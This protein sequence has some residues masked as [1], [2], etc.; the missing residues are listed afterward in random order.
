MPASI[1]ATA[2]TAGQPAPGATASGAS[3]IQLAQLQKAGGNYA[4][5]YYGLYTN[6]GDMNG[7][8]PAVDGNQ[9]I[10]LVDPNTGQ[11]L[12]EGKGQQGAQQIATL[13]NAVSQDLGRK[14]GWRVEYE[15]EPEKFT[16]VGTDRADPKSDLLKTLVRVAAPLLV[17][18][19]PGVGPALAGAL[20]VGGSGAALA[21]GAG[22]FLGNLLTGNSLGGSLLAGLG[23]GAGNSLGGALG[24]VV[25]GGPVSFAGTNA[26]GNLLS[27]GGFGG[28]TSSALPGA[29][30]SAAGSSI[31]SA[32]AP[33]LL[34]AGIN[35]VAPLTITA[36]STALPAALGSA[37][38]GSLG[39]LVT[40]PA[41]SGGGG[42][43]GPERVDMVPPPSF[44][45]P[46]GGVALTPPGFESTAGSLGGIG[47]GNGGALAGLGD[48]ARD[49]AAQTVGDVGGNLGVYGLAQLLGLGPQQLAS[50]IAPD[51][52]LPGSIPAEGAQSLEAPSDTA[53][54][55]PNL[56]EPAKVRSDLG[57]KPVAIPDVQ[58]PTLQETPYS[59][60]AASRSGDPLTR[61]GQT[62][63]SALSA[64][65][66]G[67]TFGGGGGGAALGQALALASSGGGAA[68]APASSAPSDLNA[69]SSA[70]PEIYPWRQG[71]EQQQVF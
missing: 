33:G 9:R 4:T 35:T 12:V 32:A 71:S 61:P 45:A 48:F 42:L 1:T 53:P 15:F 37:L 16:S 46:D 38:G 29:A 26:L 19:I 49:T 31:T 13:A 36:G 22:G 41:G 40:P 24:G 57:N 69:Q 56:G 62:P 60:K 67:A 7:A 14:A 18:A 44:T 20:G 47:F 21:A 54:N 51:S 55:L 50:P 27:A 8:V 70:P 66:P 68:T 30:G 43:Q 65:L 11:T 3:P 52:A 6:S 28:L 25:S 5:D 2:P 64:S 39:S 10:R 34:E 63:A 23:A 58:G 17:A 59:A